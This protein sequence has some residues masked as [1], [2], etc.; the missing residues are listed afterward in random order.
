[1][2]SRPKCYQKRILV[3]YPFVSEQG[4]FDTILALGYSFCGENH[5]VNTTL[6]RKRGYEAPFYGTPSQRKRF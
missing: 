6:Q 5:Y 4:H 3:P 1:M 2:V